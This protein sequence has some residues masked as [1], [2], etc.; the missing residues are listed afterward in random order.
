MNA[1]EIEQAVS[2]L[3]SQPYDATEFPYQFLE[4]FGNKA[5]TIKRLRAG[6]TNRSDCGGVLQRDNIHI[7]IAPPGATATTLHA[8]R[9]SPATAKQKAKL[10]L[11]TDGEQLEAGD[12]ASG[13]TLAC[14]YADLPDHFGFFLTLAGIKTIRQIRDSAFDIR[15]TS[16]L[17]QLYIQ[18]LQDNPDWGS[19]ARRHDMNHFM[20]RL[21]FC[22]FAEDTDVFNGGNLFTATIDQMSA[23]DG[24]DTAYVI[25]EIFRAI[26]LN[27]IGM[28]TIQSRAIAGIANRTLIFCLPGSTNACRTAWEQIIRPQLDPR[29]NAC[30]FTRVFNAW[31]K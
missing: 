30:G 14:A 13:E 31:G 23:A 11:A 24:S 29:I 2:E 6:D 16:R 10:I 1:I 20:A 21:I 3:F 25:G 17:N 12:L 15:A 9:V 26:S 28:S 22:F 4:A 5:T 19:A 27:E 8:L 18:L 7:A